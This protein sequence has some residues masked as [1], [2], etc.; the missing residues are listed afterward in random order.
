M[1]NNLNFGG[2]MQ[3][4][5]L[6]TVA[7]SL[8]GSFI[9][10]NY[11]I[12][13]YAAEID[14]VNADTYGTG[15][16][17]NTTL[18]TLGLE[19][20]PQ[21]NE[22]KSILEN[23]GDNNILVERKDENNLA[24]SKVTDYV[25]IRKEATEESEVVGK[26]Y[27]NSAATIIETEGDWS[28][29]ESGSVTGYIKTE[30]LAVGEEADELSKSVG[31]R[32]ATVNTT[33]LKVRKEPAIDSKVLTLVPIEEKLDVT[34]ESDGW[35]KVSI[36]ADILGY[37]SNEYVDLITE[38]KE[39]ESIEEEKARLAIE[40]AKK[41]K[42]QSSSIKAEEKKKA[43]SN[44]KST[45]RQAIV[46][47]ALQFVGNP[48]VWGGTSLTQGADCSGF[49]QSVFRDNNIS[50]PRTSR[51]QA[52]SGTTISIDAMQP[53]DLIFY[54]NGDAIDHVALY[55]G[56]GKVVAASSPATGIRVTKYNYRQ[57]YKVV[58]YIN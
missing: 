47:Y 28:K 21:S 26:L 50:I 3:K 6:K 32:I 52:G 48:Y 23:T 37:V 36:D 29:I 12:H 40:E 20:I 49:T 13:T 24:I 39:A 4:R 58:S 45:K 42:I 8:I 35:V 41:Q 9:L 55:I 14:M 1:C 10:S 34:E 54:T 27:A 25:N 18:A 51:T 30:F 56:S 5:I 38:Y 17:M 2:F 22:G 11:S 7:F 15:F 19:S 57:P 31:K 53:G 16:Y 46:D 43:V 33:T 44:S